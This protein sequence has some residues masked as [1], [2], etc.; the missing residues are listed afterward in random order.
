MADEQPNNPFSCA[1]I[2]PS[3]LGSSALFFA[4]IVR[5]CYC[6]ASA[7]KFHVG[8]GVT[9]A[10]CVPIILTS[11][12]ATTPTLPAS[13]VP[14][15]LAAMNEAVYDGANAPDSACSHPYADSCIV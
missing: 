12:T 8:V 5:L 3:H 11:R 13:P 9:I 1:L 14:L 15:T 6:T 4:C 2:S 10:V 7:P